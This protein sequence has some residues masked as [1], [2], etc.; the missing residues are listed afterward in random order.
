MFSAK[1]FVIA[2]FATMLMTACGFHLRGATSMTA[3]TYSTL[4]IVADQKSNLTTQLQDIMRGQVILVKP[5]APAQ[6]IAE[7][8]EISHSKAVSNT[9][10]AGRAVEYRL[11]TSAT[12]QAYTA[13]KNQLIPPSRISVSRTLSAGDGYDTSLDLETARL[14][15]DLD[16]ELA[17]QM[18][19]RLR[20]IKLSASK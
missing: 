12:L 5:P 19:Y 10:S 2:S 7:I 13:Q 4:S 17:T 3:V 14:Y 20:S 18:Q 15:N 9:N 11:T 16:I 8:G 6:V 1:K